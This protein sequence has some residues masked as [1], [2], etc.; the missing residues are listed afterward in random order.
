M[1]NLQE[2]YQSEPKAKFRYVDW[3]HQTKFFQ[4]KKMSTCGKY[5]LGKLDCGTEAI[6]PVESDFWEKYF[7][8]DEHVAR[9]V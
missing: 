9:A 2:L 5:Y 3:N 6:F 7:E 1:Q 4:V 8:G